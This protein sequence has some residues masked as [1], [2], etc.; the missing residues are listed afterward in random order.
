M[1]S[2]TRTFQQ[3]AA[4]LLQHYQRCGLTFIPKPAADWARGFVEAASIDDSGESQVASNSVPSLS[5]QIT[6]VGHAFAK[7]RE[8][9][10]AFAIGARSMGRQRAIAAREAIGIGFAC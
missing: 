8:D 6:V 5:R 4:Q 7:H 2:T 3:S 10:A 9:F 1:N